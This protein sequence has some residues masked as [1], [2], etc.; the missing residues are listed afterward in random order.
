MLLLLWSLPTS[1]TPL[2]SH[3]IILLQMFTLGMHFQ[4]ISNWPRLQLLYWKCGKMKGRF[5]PLIWWSQIFKTHCK[6][7]FQW[8]WKCTPRSFL[9]LIASLQCNT[10]L[11]ALCKELWKWHL[12]FLQN[13]NL[14]L[15]S[16]IVMLLKFHRSYDFDVNACSR[17]DVIECGRCLIYGT[18][19]D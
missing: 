8:L 12:R 9:S 1:L 11:L 10:W 2:P 4:N 5:Q 3:G 7:T 6:N 17:C 19:C 18:R 13:S 16:W 14:R 15:S